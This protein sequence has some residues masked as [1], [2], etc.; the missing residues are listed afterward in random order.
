MQDMSPHFLSV[1]CVLPS[2]IDEWPPFFPWFS[3]FCNQEFIRSVLFFYA[4]WWHGKSHCHS[5]CLLKQRNQTI[6]CS[7]Q[8][9]LGKFP[10]ECRWGNCG[11][12]QSFEETWLKLWWVKDRL[13]ILGLFWFSCVFISHYLFRNILLLERHEI[14]LGWNINCL[15]IHLNPDWLSLGLKSPFTHNL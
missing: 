11:R 14:Q 13:L 12:N 3:Q 10:L 6:F 15:A 7:E 5:C 9:D 2:A 1:A 8:R 4:E